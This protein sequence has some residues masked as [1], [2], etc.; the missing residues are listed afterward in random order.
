MSLEV[1]IKLRFYSSAQEKSAILA[2]YRQLFETSK[3]PVRSDT[4]MGSTD[5]KKQTKS[6]VLEIIPLL[7][8]GSMIPGLVDG[9]I[10]TP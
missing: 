3:N 2:G 8:F 6:R 7:N 5:R 9:G 1:L 10:L 4:V